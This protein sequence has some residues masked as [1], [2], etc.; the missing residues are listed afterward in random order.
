MTLL[1]TDTEELS[2]KTFNDE[3]EL[4]RYAILSHTWLPDIGD[5]A[6]EV[7]YG[8]LGTGLFTTKAGLPKVEFARLQA[9]KHGLDFIWID[10]C[11]IDKSS[12]A[13]LSE[14]I[15]SM[16][17]WYRNAK[18]CHVYLDD[19][20]D[21][22]APVL[23]DNAAAATDMHHATAPEHDATVVT[24]RSSVDSTT[25]AHSQ[26]YTAQLHAIA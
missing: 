11:C 18:K 19:M 12:S 8:D 16:Y 13:E 6:Q 3:S 4:P 24:V 25:I 26:Q 5:A 2:L 7:L 1:R 21:Q 20:P 15:N 9:R 10:T 17:R 23:K 22:N 14:A